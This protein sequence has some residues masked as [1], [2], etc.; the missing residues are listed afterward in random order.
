ML[1][2]CAMAPPP[3]SAF[4]QRCLQYSLANPSDI[5][6]PVAVV[7]KKVVFFFLGGGGFGEQFPF[8]K[9]KLLQN[10]F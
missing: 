5:T 3:S 10:R 4:Q 9:L 1:F 6:T 7:K 2:M 8:L